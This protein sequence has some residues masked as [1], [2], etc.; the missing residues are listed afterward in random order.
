MMNRVSINQEGRIGLFTVLIALWAILTA[1]ILWPIISDLNPS[2]SKL[3]PPEPGGAN[4]LV[5]APQALGKGAAA[6]EDYRRDT[7][8]QAKVVLLSPEQE[9]VEEIRELIQETYAESG[10]P[11]PFYVLL[12]GHAHPFSSHS[13]TY[14]PAAHFSVDPRRFSGYGTDPIASEDGY[15]GDLSSG[16]PSN[17]LPIFIGRIPVRTEEEAFLLLERTRNY[18]KTPISGAGRARIELVS[19]NAGFGP[20]YDPIF[21]WALRTLLQKDLPDEYGWHL[22]NGNPQSPYSYPMHLFPKEIAKRF[23][24]G[25][26]AFVYVGHA[27]PDL[28]GWACAPNGACGR[29]FN[30]EDASLI[31]N[32]NASLGIFTACSAG[33]YDLDGDNLSVVETIFLTPGGPVATYSSSAWINA[34][35]NGQMLIDLFEALL[36][37]NAPTLGEW[38]GRIE[39]RPGS[40]SSRDLFTAVVK[41]V[42]PWVSGIYEKKLLLSPAQ[43]GQALEIQHA[44]YNLFGDP[45]L[46]IAY[47]LPGMVVSPYWIWQPW[48]R[49]LAFHGSGGL[50]VGQ[51]VLI[52]LEIAP[53]NFNSRVDQIKGT[54]D[55]YLQA[56]H[57]VISLANVPVVN[58]GR[59]SGRIDIPNDTPGGKYLLKAISVH[60]NGTYVA[61]H[62]VYI[63]WP[64]ILEILSSGGFWWA[65]TSIVLGL[66]VVSLIRSSNNIDQISVGRTLRSKPMFSGIRSTKET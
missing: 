31:Q 54:I 47:P 28:L 59:F 24:S 5:I 7:G 65:M 42:L 44:T 48:K 49:S 64:P 3:K 21:E 51:Q 58:N 26:L 1:D 27:Q 11:Y 9:K 14:L 62:P 57:P 36:I 22:L 30:G 17:T 55:G 43:A 63:G 20:Q 34:T 13:D 15:A 53:G 52:S 33:K 8:Y 60:N 25:A 37:D 35:L 4:Y 10:K 50:A 39:T 18:E 12:I 56:N 23:D 38:V 41:S 46:R 19:S 2:P 16:I 40:T 61:A 6:W 32:A 29:I 66:K 45:A